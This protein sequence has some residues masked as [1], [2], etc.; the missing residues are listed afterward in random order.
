MPQ[1]E[2]MQ[3]TVHYSAYD[4]IVSLLNAHGADGWEIV[5]DNGTP[6]TACFLLKR[7]IVVPDDPRPLLFD[8]RG[9]LDLE[10]SS[11]RPGFYCYIDGRGPTPLYCTESQAATAAQDY[12]TWLVFT[13]EEQ[14]EGENCGSCCMCL[15]GCRT[16]HDQGLR[17]EV[18]N[19]RFVE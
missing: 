8:D 11:D 16:A 18:C 5:L 10:P 9:M 6:D 3:L 4:N 17:P 14:L 19:H 1:F 2:Y 13:L 7:Q 15:G 12:P